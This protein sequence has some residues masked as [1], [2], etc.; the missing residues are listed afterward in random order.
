LLAEVAR[1][2]LRDADSLIRLHEILLF[3][4]AHPQGP[5][6]LRQTDA[7]LRGF[8]RRVDEARAASLDLTPLTRPEVSGIARTEFSLL[9]SYETVRWLARAHPARTEID[10]DGFEDRAQLGVVLPLL[11]PLYEEDA[12]VD[13]HAPF[14]EWIRTAKRRGETDLGF[15]VR[16]FERLPLSEKQ[17]AA[18]SKPGAGPSAPGAENRLPAPGGRPQDPAM[19]ES[20]LPMPPSATS[21]AAGRQRQPCLR[22]G[23]APSR[24]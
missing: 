19:P 7:L 17:R 4:R 2:R 6:L 22:G 18:H 15:L 1:R 5:Q 10:W 16:G 9:M 8:G 14:L 23:P 24:S 3:M 11:L 12:Y 21:P 20:A 13:A